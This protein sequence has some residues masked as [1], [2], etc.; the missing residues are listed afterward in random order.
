MAVVEFYNKGAGREDPQLDGRIRP[1]GLNEAEVANLAAFLG[2]L[3][4][5]AS[6]QAAPSVSPAAD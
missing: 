3:S 2:A 1:L 6:V 4:R 5:E